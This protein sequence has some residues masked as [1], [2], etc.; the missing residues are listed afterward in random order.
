MKF[1]AYL[2]PQVIFTNLAFHEVSLRS[3]AAYVL[4]AVIRSYVLLQTSRILAVESSGLYALYRLP[5]NDMKRNIGVTQ[6]DVANA[7]YV[8]VCLQSLSS[9]EYMD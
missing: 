8:G 7:H 5:G 6:I 3:L 9:E 4:S 2:K 1:F